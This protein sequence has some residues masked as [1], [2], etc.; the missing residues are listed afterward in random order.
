MKPTIEINEENFEIEV[1]KSNQPV[2]V[3]FSTGSSLPSMTL[4]GVPEERSLDK[5]NG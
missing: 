3:G 2:V 5:R 1:L 4:D